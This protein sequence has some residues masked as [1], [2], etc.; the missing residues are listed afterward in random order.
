[1]TGARMTEV[2][3]L[4][5]ALAQAGYVAEPALAAALL[6]MLG[7]ERPLLLEGDALS[8]IHI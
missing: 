7:L 8:L 2:A 4:Q 3:S 6:L 5:Q 1:M